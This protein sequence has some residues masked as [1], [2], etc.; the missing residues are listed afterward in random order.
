MESVDHLK[1]YGGSSHFD[2]VYHL[3]VFGGSSLK[4]RWIISWT[5]TQGTHNVTFSELEKP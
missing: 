4:Y 2:S 1:T 3:T 5:V